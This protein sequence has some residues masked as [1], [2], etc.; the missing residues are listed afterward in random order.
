MSEAPIDPANRFFEPVF[1]S[2]VFL[3]LGEKWLT[4]RSRQNRVRII[5]PRPLAELL[6]EG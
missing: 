1:P 5:V 6:S 3:A 2:V 4:D